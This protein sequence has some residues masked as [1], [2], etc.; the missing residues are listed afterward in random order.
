[1]NSVIKN[2]DDAS[3][4]LDTSIISVIQV[5]DSDAAE[6]DKSELGQS[7]VGD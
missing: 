2:E 3:S 4:A 1:M 6:K 5:K 7:F